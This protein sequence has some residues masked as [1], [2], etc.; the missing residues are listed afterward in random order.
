MHARGNSRI[1]LIAIIALVQIAAV[2]GY[3]GFNN[4]LTNE[5][6]QAQMVDVLDQASHNADNSMATFTDDVNL[7]AQTIVRLVGDSSQDNELEMFHALEYVPQ[8]SGAYQGSDTGEFKFVFRSDDGYGT[9]RVTPA[10]DDTAREVV[11]TDRSATFELLGTRLDPED[12]YDP[13]E[14]PWFKQATAQGSGVVWT[15]PYTFFTS[16]EPG[17]TLAA[18]IVQPDKSWVVG[19]DVQLSGVVDFMSELSDQTGGEAFLFDGNKTVLSQH[20]I[21][22]LDTSGDSEDLTPEAAEAFNRIRN[23]IAGQKGDMEPSGDGIVEAMDTTWDV[24]GVSHLSRFIAASSP[25][26]SVRDGKS[27]LTCPKP[28][29][30]RR[31]AG[32]SAAS[33]CWP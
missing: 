17:V 25:P 7:A 12:V 27:D 19:V 5:G 21:M 18:Q 9:K 10:T 1:V 30:Q 28:R 20:G 32:C 11:L 24:D 31:Y 16:G 6:V 15:D 23:A 22:N 8:L 4:R 26:T 33:G 14:R 3:L 13:R 2:V 29:S